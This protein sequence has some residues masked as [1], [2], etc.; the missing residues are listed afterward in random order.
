MLGIF[1]RRGANGTRVFTDA[2]SGTEEQRQWKEWVAVA[3]A[4]AFLPVMARAQTPNL[5]GTWQMDVAKSQVT[6]GRVVTLIIESSSG[7]LKLMRTEKSKSGPEVVSQFVCTVDGKE[8]D[9]DEG[10]HKSKVMAWYVG[11][12]LHVDKTNGPEG[13]VVDEWKFELAPG[14]KGLTVAI[15]HLEPSGK[16]ETLVFDKKT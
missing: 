11:P 7:K 14:G 10:G 16:D 6:D 15:G 3:A 5:S 8:C 12:V 13:D 4:I 9:Y 2:R 1:I